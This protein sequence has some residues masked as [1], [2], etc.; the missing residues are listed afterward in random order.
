MRS[1][2]GL[3]AMSFGGFIV[4]PPD[5]RGAV[6]YESSGG[7]GTLQI[8]DNNFTQV[9]DQVFPAGEDRHIVSAVVPFATFSNADDPN[10][11]NDF[12]TPEYR[13]EFLRLTL[14]ESDG[15]LP[16]KEIASSTVKGPL[17][18]KGGNSADGGTA[19]TFPFPS[20]EVP[21]VFAFGVVNL[22]AAKEYESTSG[23]PNLFGVL[24]SQ[25]VAPDPDKPGTSS[26]TLLIQDG[27]GWRTDN[28]GIDQADVDATFIAV[29]EPASV[30][31]LAL[32]GGVL[33]CRRP[34]RR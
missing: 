28:Q 29:P 4:S 7:K 11:P 22:N 18:P 30:A 15:A 2:L 3:F 26:T 34:R 8:S 12:F 10:D 13:P 25:N 14:Y 27:D 6:V 5:T 21:D 32:A 9:G 16:G 17:F 24:V 20:V 23:K 33:A 1:A 19:V 31:L